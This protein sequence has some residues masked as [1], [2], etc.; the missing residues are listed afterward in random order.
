MSPAGVL[1]KDGVAH[2]HHGAP[3]SRPIGKLSACLGSATCSFVVVV[4]IIVPLLVFTL[5]S[6][7]ATIL[8]AIECAEQR[9]E[10]GD[11]RRLSESADMCLWYEWFK[12]I[13]G[14]LV[15]ISL[16]DVADG[17][18][19]HAFAEVALTIALLCISDSYF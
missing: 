3:V 4:V 8:W 16:T 10:S 12:Y 15:G 5:S 13:V 2:H 14:N 18:S 19:G 6:V 1:Q 11:S 17:M 9:S 7:F